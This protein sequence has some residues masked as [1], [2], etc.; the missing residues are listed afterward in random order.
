MN[1]VVQRLKSYAIF[2]AA[3]IVFMTIIWSGV[4]FIEYRVG[5]ETWLVTF[6]VAAWMTF[7]F[8]SLLGFLMVLHRRL[9]RVND[10]EGGGGGV[11][12]V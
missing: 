4:Y 6:L 5:Y 2:W 11:G 12:P 3:T 9:K 10:D 8:M 7:C 1:N